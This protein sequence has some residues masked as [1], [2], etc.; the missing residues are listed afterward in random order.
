M[1]QY[2]IFLFLL[3][4]QQSI[5]AQKKNQNLYVEILGASNTIGINYDSH[6]KGND[7]LGFRIGL[8]YGYANDKKFFGEKSTVKGIGIPTELNYLLGNKNHKFE[9]GVGVNVGVYRINEE[10]S[11]NSIFQILDSNLDSYDTRKDK[12]TQFGYFIFGDLGYR[13]QPLNGFLFRVGI[14]PSFNFGDK[15][16]IKKSFFYP[17]I[18]LGWGF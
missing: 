3:L 4:F 1:K 5:A 7:G 16:G 15:Y 18:G 2:F 14:S 12:R 10:V 11:S 17:Y 6:I 8:G 9:M 13:Y